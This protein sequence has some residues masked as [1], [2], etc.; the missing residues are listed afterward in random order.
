MH[1][2]VALLGFPAGLPRISRAWNTAV[3]VR[4]A[5]WV[6]WIKLISY[7]RRLREVPKMHPRVA[8][9]VVKWQALAYTEDVFRAYIR[10]R[11]HEPTWYFGPGWAERDL[12]ELFGLCRRQ[13]KSGDIHRIV[14][15]RIELTQ[16]RD[17]PRAIAHI[18][19]CHKLPDVAAAHYLTSCILILK[20][21]RI[22]SWD[23]GSH[24]L[25]HLYAYDCEFRSVSGINHIGDFNT[26][27]CKFVA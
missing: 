21:M 10:P 4:S 19:E 18:V 25:D 14:F 2:V 22:D 20:N 15:D 27:N 3:G 26:C 16:T 13:L 17:W 23:L 6:P 8:E 7:T 12:T 11:S 24:P 5:A 9:E 1:R